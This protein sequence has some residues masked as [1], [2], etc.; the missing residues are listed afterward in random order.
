VLTEEQRT[1]QTPKPP[2]EMPPVLSATGLLWPAALF[3]VL[4]TAWR[5][6]EQRRPI[7][8]GAAFTS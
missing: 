5:W 3:L 7:V 6:R 8:S 2:R 1:T 4:L